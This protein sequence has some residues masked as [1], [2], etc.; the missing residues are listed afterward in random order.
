M[1]GNGRFGGHFVLG[2]VDDKGVIT[3]VKETPNSRIHQ[4]D[5]KQNDLQNVHFLTLL[6]LS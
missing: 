6:F 4:H 1:S 3:Q 5:L 2:H